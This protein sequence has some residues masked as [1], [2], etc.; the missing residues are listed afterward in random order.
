MQRLD[1]TSDLLAWLDTRPRHEAIT[2][3]NATGWPASTWILHAMY[4]NP[5]LTGLGTYD[6]VHRRRLAAGDVAPLS[7]GGIDVDVATTVTGTPLGFVARPAAPWVR[8]AWTE[9]VHR[10][11]AF[12]P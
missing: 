6:D 10:F 3:F 1:D 2:G 8:L 5:D 11:P 9:Y 4:E 12:S 7:I